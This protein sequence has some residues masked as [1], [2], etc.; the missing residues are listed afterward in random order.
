MNMKL[1]FPKW[2]LTK[3]VSICSIANDE[4]N[5]P[6]QSVIFSGKAR[7]DKK[8][9]QILNAQRELVM[10]SGVVVCEGDIAIPFD[11]ST[12][13]IVDGQEKNVIRVNKP[14]NPDG[15]VFS[16]ELMLE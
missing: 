2:T 10:I 11:K 14:D 7:Y 6:T 3:T 12:I 15:S 9:K 5:K 4:N 8:S 16:T 13:V 1:P